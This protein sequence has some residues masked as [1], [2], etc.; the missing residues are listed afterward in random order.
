L[1]CYIK[2]NTH[3]RRGVGVSKFAVEVLGYVVIVV[4]AIALEW[5]SARRNAPANVARLEEQAGASAPPEA[6]RWLRTE[7]IRRVRWTGAGPLVGLTVGLAFTSGEV[8]ARAYA[9]VVMCAA[10][11]ALVG[12]I[13]AA[14]LTKPYVSGPVR[15]ASLRPRRVEDYLLPRQWRGNRLSL[16]LTGAALV[17]SLLYTVVTAPDSA[18]MA[19]AA[20]AAFLIVVTSLRVQRAVVA[21][22]HAARTAA[23]LFWQEQLLVDTLS[24]LPRVTT[25]AAVVTAA[26]TA[27]VVLVEA[28]SWWLDWGSLGVL[29][30][31]AV[32]TALFLPRD[33]EDEEVVPALRGLRVSS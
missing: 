6:E 11:G 7:L 26:C 27:G 20:C 32:V 29:L 12:A 33:G 4:A 31:S 5:R 30:A 16:A 15:S 8:T 25:F 1:Y 28:T 13:V 23:D 24:S 2:Y 17:L 21:R 18:W 14:S 9:V 10:T 22:P 3:Y 19:V